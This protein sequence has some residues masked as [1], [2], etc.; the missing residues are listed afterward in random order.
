MAIT[1]EIIEYIAMLARLQLDENEEANMVSDISKVISYFDKLKELDTSNIDA[2][3]FLSME[4]DVFENALRDD[5]VGQ[6][7]E[8]AQ[9]LHPEEEE[10]S[11]YF[12]VPKVVE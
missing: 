5:V 12:T 7:Y 1:K 9:L 8:R 4:E 2:M 3:E 11:E 10:D 6:S